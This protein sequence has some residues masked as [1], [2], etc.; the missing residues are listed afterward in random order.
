MSSNTVQL[1]IPFIKKRVHL[2]NSNARIFYVTKSYILCMLSIK[3]KSKMYYIFSQST[4]LLF[5]I[6]RKINVC[7]TVSFF[8]C[9][10][11]TKACYIGSNK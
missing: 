11:C 6:E 3:L 2:K 10:H 9:L 1:T 7:W 5:H 4:L 8:Y